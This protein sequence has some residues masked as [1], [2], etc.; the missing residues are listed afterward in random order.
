MSDDSEPGEIKSPDLTSINR[1]KRST[2]DKR[3]YKAEKKIK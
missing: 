1:S 2:E 3:S